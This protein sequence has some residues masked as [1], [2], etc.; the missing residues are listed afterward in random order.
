MTKKEFEYWK[1]NS[2]K[3]SSAYQ[4]IVHLYYPDMLNTYYKSKE[5]KINPDI[6]YVTEKSDFHSV[7]IDGNENLKVEFMNDC[8]LFKERIV[9][10]YF[11]R[12]KRRIEKYLSRNFILNVFPRK[13]IKQF[14]VRQ[15]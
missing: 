3:I 2:D 1:N 11:N 10:I 4:V 6:K 9:N 8:I 7:V 5:N 14:E 13:F 12:E 15:N